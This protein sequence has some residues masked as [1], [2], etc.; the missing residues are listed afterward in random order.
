MRMVKKVS[1]IVLAALGSSTYGRRVR[2]RSLLAAALLESL[3]DHPL[4][5]V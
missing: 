5:N 1:S 2:L 4:V 3:L